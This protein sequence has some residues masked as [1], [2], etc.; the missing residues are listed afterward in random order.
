MTGQHGSAVRRVEAALEKH[1]CRQGAPGMWQCP[2]PEHEDHDPSLSVRQGNEGALV[3]CQSRRCPLEDILGALGLDKGAL[4]DNPREKRQAVRPQVVAEYPYV[5]EHGELLYT[6]KRFEPGHGGKRKSFLPYLPGATRAGLGAVRRVP[7]RLPQLLRAIDAGET[8]YIAE[9][10]KSVDALSERGVTATTNPNGAGK[11]RPEFDPYFAGA[12]VV[13]VA[14]RDDEGVSHARNVAGQLSSIA[15]SV[16]IVQAAVTGAKADIVEHL[17]AGHG[18]G[19]LVPLDVKAHAESP[20]AASGRDWQQPDADAYDPENPVALLELAGKAAA[21]ERS[22]V[23]VWAVRSIAAS[24]AAP[25]VLKV[26][27]RAVVKASGLMSLDSYDDLVRHSLAERKR[28]EP[29]E[30]DHGPSAATQLVEIAQ[31]MFAFGVSDLG[32]PFALP[33]D[34]PKVVSMLR[35]SRTSLRALLAREYF[36]RAG[37]AA[38]QQALADAL[39]VLEGMAQETEPQAL[40]LRTAQHGGSLWLDLGDQTGRAVEIGS[41]GWAVRDRPPVLFKRTSLTGALP[42]PESGGELAD[43]WDWLNVSKDD[44]P[45]ILAALVHALFSDEPHVV[46]AILGEQGTAKTTAAKVLVL[47]LDPGPVPTRKPPRDADSW[48]TAASGS[49]MVALDNLSDIPAWLSDAMCRASTGEGDVRRKLYTDGDFAVFAFR[50]CI[51]FNG[52]DVGALAPDLAERSVPVVLDLIPDENRKP[53]KIFWRNWAA[54]HPKLLGAIVDLAVTVL[55]NPVR[56]EKSP[57]MADYADVLAAVDVHLGT[58]ARE[59]Y[60]KQSAALAADSLSSSP[61]A[62]CIQAAVT[63][64]FEGTSAELL[65]AVT[66]ADPDWRAPKDWPTKPRQVTSWMRRLA[67]AFRKTGWKVEDLGAENHAKLIRWNISPPAQPEKSGD[68]PANPRIPRRMRVLRG[69]AGMTPGLLRLS[70]GRGVAA[71]AAARTRQALAASCARYARHHSTGMARRPAIT[72]ANPRTSARA[73]A[74]RL[75][76]TFTPQPAPQQLGKEFILGARTLAAP[77]RQPR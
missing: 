26:L 68:D 38:S 3:K 7:Y 13:V 21:S 11:W 77:G 74:T 45:L 64:R 46:L 55:A 51:L 56:T 8:V 58:N 73:A 63:D 44:R 34:G 27:G 72:P 19:D 10:E 65:D 31:E 6:V 33:V 25:Y 62:V 69:L 23:A 75:I 49:W 1:D 54:A 24:D 39:L 61:F 71:Q 70:S 36:S 2:V 20:D 47:L 32:E 12:K 42:E 37:R 5:D 76:A 30:G 15:A 28:S 52:I 67:P 57:R 35:G 59:R 60:A 18:L 41:R 16:E 17:N 9:G 43:L 29:G 14:D 53:E 4:F 50:R 48:V 66:P 40:Y 22:K